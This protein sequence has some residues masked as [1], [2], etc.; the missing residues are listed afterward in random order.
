MFAL[1]DFP[2]APGVYIMKDAR[3][4]A[5]YIGK[6][7]SLRK[8]LR[9]YFYKQPGEGRPK[10]EAML[11]RVEHIDYI[12]T[13]TEAEALLLEAALIKRNRPRYNVALKDD[14][15][16]PLIKV[17]RRERFPGV[18]VARRRSGQDAL[19]F[20]PYAHPGLLK[21]ALNALRRIFPY[22]VCRRLLKRPCLDYELGLCP[23]PCAGKIGV[24]EY[25]QN[26]RNLCLFLSGSNQRLV[27]GLKAQMEAAARE[28]NFEKAGELRDKILALSAVGRGPMAKRAAFEA[29]K[30]KAALGIKAPLR[31]IEAF[32]VSSI[33]GTSVVG[34]MVSFV[35]GVADKANYRRFRIKGQHKDD[36]AAMAEVVRRRYS[37]LL[38]EGGKFPDLIIVDGGKGHLGV[39]CAELRALNLDIAI[40]A[41]AKREEEIFF[42]GRNRPLRLPR[43]S[44]A[45]NLARRI[46]DEAHR[47]AVSYHR[48]LRRVN[49]IFPPEA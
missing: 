37:R 19:Y 27:L 14:K 13:S 10:Q 4:R 33:S 1:N 5:V 40:I 47:F 12:L 16:Y 29:E 25:R 18:S 39:A 44:A 46:R 28:R 49:A 17:S 8:R 7:A 36:C 11:A 24:R 34:S 26:I 31:R 3:G 23:A 45:L 42:L 32:D 22:R 41:I 48:L 2:D 30:L 15:N 9:S 21:E 20:G 35:N 43:E 38:R 6:A